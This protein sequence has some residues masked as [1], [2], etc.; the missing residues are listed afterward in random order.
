MLFTEW[1]ETQDSY[2]RRSYGLNLAKMSEEERLKYIDEMLKAAI[3]EIGEAFNEFS[4]KSWASN[5]FLNRDALVGEGID[6]LFFMANVFV[7]LGVTS[8]ELDRRYRGKMAINTLRQSNGYDTSAPG[9][10]CPKCKR[11]LDDTAVTCTPDHC[12]EE[13]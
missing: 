4:W 10:K 12:S 3:L 13:S 1:L 11:G 6:V 2:Q 8:D 7:A 9:V 5:Q